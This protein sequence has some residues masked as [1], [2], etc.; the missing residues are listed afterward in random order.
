MS[1]RYTAISLRGNRCSWAERGRRTV[2]EM[3][4]ILRAHAQKEKDDAEAVLAALDGDFRVTTFLGIYAHRRSE[5]LQ[6]GKK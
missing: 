2:P 1:E 6:E 3:V 4:D 5:T